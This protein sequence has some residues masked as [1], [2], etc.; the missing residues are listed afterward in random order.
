MVRMRGI[1][2]TNRA[3]HQ[4][5]DGRSVSWLGGAHRYDT[6]ETRNKNRGKLSPSSHPRVAPDVTEVLS[7]LETCSAHRYFLRLASNVWPRLRSYRHIFRNIY[8]S[9]VMFFFAYFPS[10]RILRLRNTFTMA[11]KASASL[12]PKSKA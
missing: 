6:F 10:F 4:H 8:E 11:S 9:A 12:A 2:Y 1:K 3:H 5:I 7:G